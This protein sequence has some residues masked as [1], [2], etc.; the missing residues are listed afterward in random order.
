MI[1]IRQIKSAL[2]RKLGG[3]TKMDLNYAI[4]QQAAATYRKTSDVYQK[5]LARIRGRVAAYDVRDDFGRRVR[6]EDLLA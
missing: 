1:S 6:V 4:A 5:K 3:Y 2:I